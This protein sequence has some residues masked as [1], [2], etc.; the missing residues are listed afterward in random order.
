[1]TLEESFL[2]SPQS[3]KYLSSKSKKQL[4]G[5]SSQVTLHLAKQFMFIQKEMQKKRENKSY[6]NIKKSYVIM[7]DQSTLKFVFRS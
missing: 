4:S 5:A 3:A 7:E 2:D 1:M 6:I